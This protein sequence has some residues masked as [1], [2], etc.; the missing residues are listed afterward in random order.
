MPG[1]SITIVAIAVC[2]ASCGG[3]T[4]VRTDSKPLPVAASTEAELD[5]S[6]ARHNPAYATWQLDVRYTHTKDSSGCRPSDAQ[7]SASVTL[8]R[9]T[10]QPPAS[11]P[12]ALRD[13]WRRY[14]AA[15]EKRHAKRKP[16]AERYARKLYAQ[17]RRL[18]QPTCEALDAKADRLRLLLRAQHDAEQRKLAPVTWR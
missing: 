1:R 9:P 4:T 10:W 8:L 2:V 11:A 14:T 3:K 5:A 18:L 15:I 12:P 17:T 7:V 13:R 16:I 6:V